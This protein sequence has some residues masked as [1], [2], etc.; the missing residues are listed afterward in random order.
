MNRWRQ[1]L[2]GPDGDIVRQVIEHYRAQIEHHRDV[3]APSIMAALHEAADR[4]MDQER[5]KP[6]FQRV[7]CK[8]GCSA[9]CHIE[10]DVTAGEA[11]L[12]L[13]AAADAGHDVDRD[14]VELQ[15]TTAW[16]DLPIEDRACVFLR[17]NECAIYQYRPLACRLHMVVD[18]ADFCDTVKYPGHETKN[19]VIKEAE[20]ILAAALLSFESGTMAKMVRKEWTPN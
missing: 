11:N 2:E 3:D 16:D 8:R 9:C 4:I 12:A 19:L 18:T 20:A 10:V 5:H 6:A 14:R 15:A 7:A 13:Q 17:G 1:L